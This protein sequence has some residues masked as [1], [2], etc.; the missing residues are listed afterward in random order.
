MLMLVV[1][2]EEAVR[3]NKAKSSWN[4]G[5]NQD[6]VPIPLRTGIY[7]AGLNIF[8]ES[9]LLITAFREKR[10]ANTASVTPVSPKVGTNDADFSWN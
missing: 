10:E 6:G 7:F 9:L 8:K 1:G 3:K 5:I 4:M 2:Y